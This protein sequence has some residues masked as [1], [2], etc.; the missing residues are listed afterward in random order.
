MLEIVDLLIAFMKLY[1]YHKFVPKDNILLLGRLCLFCCVEEARS[2]I[3]N[4][5]ASLGGQHKVKKT[6]S[7]S[8]MKISL[9]LLP[10]C[11]VPKFKTVCARYAVLRS[12]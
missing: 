9:D 6:I 2:A 8:D 3:L 5:E 11:K 4:R 10:R 12:K 7:R 1:Q